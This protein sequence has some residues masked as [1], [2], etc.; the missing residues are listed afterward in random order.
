MCLSYCLQGA[1]P[2]SDRQHTLNL[3]VNSVISSLK[4]LSEASSVA[5]LLTDWLTCTDK[6]M[7]YSRETTRIRY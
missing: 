7:S 3:S 5:L 1:T 2:D 4:T 6:D